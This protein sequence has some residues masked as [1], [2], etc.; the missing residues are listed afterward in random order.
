MNNF[1]NIR[2]EFPILKKQ[3]RGKQL[4][5][6]DNA[7]TTQKPTAAPA[8]KKSIFNTAMADALSKLNRGSD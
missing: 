1:A 7:S 5:Y 2:E 3:M 8:A 6:L 4:V